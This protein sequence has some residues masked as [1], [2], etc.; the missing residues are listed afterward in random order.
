M[1][2]E[3]NRAFVEIKAHGGALGCNRRVAMSDAKR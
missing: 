3:R 1:N 2:A